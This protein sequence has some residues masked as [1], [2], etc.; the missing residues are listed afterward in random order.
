MTFYEFQLRSAGYRRKE[1]FE[2]AKFRRVAFAALWSFNTDP[3]KLPKTEK[4]YMSL[5]IVDEDKNQVSEKQIAAFKKAM[6]QY[7]AKLKLNNG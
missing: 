7:Q 3:K 4:K 6:N 2:W 5:P 1:Q